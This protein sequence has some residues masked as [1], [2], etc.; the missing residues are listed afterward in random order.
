MESWKNF[1]K[2]KVSLGMPLAPIPFKMDTDTFLRTKIRSELPAEAFRPQPQR[3]LI[4]IPLLVFLALGTWAVVLS[5][6]PW[7][8]AFLG[9][10]LLG[11]AYTTLGFFQHEV[12]HGSVFRSRRLQNII[13]GLCLLP[14]FIPPR[15]WRIWHVELHHGNTNQ[16]DDPDGFGTVERFQRVPFVRFAAK[17]LV[18]GSGHWLSLFFLFYWVNF[19]AQLIIWKDSAARPGYEHLNRGKAKIETLLMMTFW[20]ILGFL[21]GPR[22]S[23]FGI[24]IP[25]LFGN[26]FAMSFIATNHFVRPRAKENEQFEVSMSVKTWKFFDWLYLNFSHHVEHHLFPNMNWKFTPL[27]RKSLIHHAGDRFLCPPRW[28]AIW[29]I[30]RT[31]R[32]YKDGETLFNPFTGRTVKIEEIEA[33]LIASP[34]KGKGRRVVALHLQSSQ[35]PITI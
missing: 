1:L 27:V 28:K 30:Y 4:L 29:W 25:I 21:V 34:R 10:I 11:S 16:D 3:A 26:F 14:F 15:I 19:R 33:K 17:Y 31:P 20:I 22:G 7:Y 18:P 13:A 32:V 35:G 9:S 12:L 2:S 24:L 23:L 6:L 5:P 8:A